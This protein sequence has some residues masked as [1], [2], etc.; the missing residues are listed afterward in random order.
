[1]SNQNHGTLY[2]VATPIGNLSDISARALTTLRE[3]DFIAA[4]DTRVTRR[5]LEHFGIKK[6]LVSYYKHNS[7]SGGEKVLTRL[8][9]GESCALVSDAGT[10]GISDPGEDLVR[11]CALDEIKIITI[12]GPC[13]AVSALALS[14]LDSGRFVFEGFLSTDNK[15]RFALLE[16]LKTEFRTMIFYEAPHKLIRTLTD[17][18]NFFGER[19]ISV[20]RE[21]TKIYE[22]T[23]RLT[24][25][26]AVLHFTSTPPR[27]EFVLIVEGAAASD[28][29]GDRLDEGI[30]LASVLIED[31][32]S[33]RDAVKKAADE[34]GCSRNALYKAVST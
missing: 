30:R 32:M 1:M 8:Q 29:T 24:L 11:L 14:G 15:K 28:D 5:L 12:P 18:L 20:S 3:V 22:E 19:R 7:R 2:L 33:K 31:G 17:L 23:L 4:E 9:G 26:E 10:P 21:L 6:P 27:G 34:T 25:S 13:A 16:E